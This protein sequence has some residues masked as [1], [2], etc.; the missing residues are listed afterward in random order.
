M[1]FGRGVQAAF[2]QGVVLDVPQGIFLRVF[3]DKIVGRNCKI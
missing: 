1:N 3:G 2:S